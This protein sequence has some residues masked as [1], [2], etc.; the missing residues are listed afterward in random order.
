MSNQVF[1]SLKSI[2]TII[3]LFSGTFFSG[4]TPSGNQN[5]TDTSTTE[6]RPIKETEK[7]GQD[8]SSFLDATVFVK[9]SNST[10]S[11]F[12][13][14]F[15]NQFFIVTNEHVVSNGDG[16]VSDTQIV[17]K[18]GSGQEIVSSSSILATSPLYDLA[19]LKPDKVPTNAPTITLGDSAAPRIGTEVSVFGFPFGDR[20]RTQKYPMVTMNLSRVSSLRYD[21]FRE[22]LLIQ[23]SSDL[24]PGNSGGPVVNQN[25][26]LIGILNSGIASVGISFAIPAMKLKELLN[27]TIT[28][29]SMTSK[30]GVIHLK[31]RLFDIKKK[32]D[33]IQLVYGSLNTDQQSISNELSKKYIIKPSDHSDSYSFT[34]PL[35]EINLNYGYFSL[36]VNYKSGQPEYTR[37][38]YID[39]NL[40]F[41][42][43]FRENSDTPPAKQQKKGIQ[44]PE[45]ND[46]TQNTFPEFGINIIP[47]QSII[48]LDKPRE[49]IHLPLPLRSWRLGSKHRI[50]YLIFTD[51][52]LATYDLKTKT[53]S[54]L[55]FDPGTS[56]IGHGTDCFISL[57][58]TEI[59]FITPKTI[60]S[61][62]IDISG[63][64]LLVQSGSLNSDR[65]FF[66]VQSKSFRH[67]LRLYSTKT[68]QHHHIARI[69]ICL[70]E[71]PVSG[72]F[73]ELA[74][75]PNARNVL[76]HCNARQQRFITIGN[77]AREVRY[78]DTYSSNASFLAN[79][80]F[81]LAKTTKDDQNIYDL[82]S[83]KIP[84][85]RNV[86]FITAQD[87][88]LMI[89]IEH[90]YNIMQ[91][92]RDNPSFR[93]F[94][95][96]T[97]LESDNR[98]PL[99]TT[100]LA[101]AVT[102]QNLKPIYITK[103]NLLITTNMGM[104]SFLLLKV[105]HHELISKTAHGSFFFEFLNLYSD[106]DPSKVKQKIQLEY[107]TNLT[108]PIVELLDP[109][110][111]IEIDDNGQLSIDG[112]LLE[113]GSE[114][115]FM[116][117]A[118]NGFKKVLSLN[119]PFVHSS[120]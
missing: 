10:G 109:P 95:N 98:D 48:E 24:N 41:Q 73:D 118:K 67:D 44:S 25:G 105:D 91:P 102:N 94:L 12:L 57:T 82:K 1:D 17:Y 52:S 26:E 104:K 19:I 79:S 39:S 47:D 38:F 36:L 7:S 3:L 116:I 23:L 83:T 60:E 42:A 70:S 50:L 107:F 99:L 6:D 29:L 5:E 15:E 97:S 72:Y 78:D 84:N 108:D 33:S 35:R 55:N 34:V 120:Q 59:S 62:P 115:V 61:K 101:D 40:N 8:F 64:P 103:S 4:C 110:S 51:Q 117:S 13:I 112:E 86:Y 28:H 71:S 92:D 20:L 113:N 14:K 77:N 30:P 76:I 43:K 16:G 11:G 106:F 90:K 49:T 58:K 80:E 21:D 89:R 54:F 100:I 96:G 27:G 69:E 63:E 53:F 32:I 88:D 46:N 87:S 56:T 37:L 45:N 9:T 22:L 75:S 114:V 31:F 65:I 81:Y 66:V 18:S 2:V 93:L 68:K 74:V 111:G 85:Y 119:F